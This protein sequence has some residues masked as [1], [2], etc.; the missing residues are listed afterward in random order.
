M[1]EVVSI[2]NLSKKFRSQKAV[3]NVNFTI[4]KGQICGLIGRNGAG[5]TTILKMLTGLM[6]SSEGSISLFGKDISKDYSVIKKI[7]AMI[8][9]PR[10]FDNMTA[11][12]NLKIK[13]LAIGDNNFNKIDELLKFVELDKTG[14]KKAKNFSYGMKQRLSLALALAGEPELLIL[15]EPINGLDPQGIAEVR[16]IILKV[17][18]EKNTTVIISSHVLEELTKIATQYVFIDKGTILENMTSKELEARQKGKMVLTVNDVDK[19]SK[20]LEKLDFKDIKIVD[21]S[22]IEVYDD[23]DNMDSL[24][25]D[26]VKNDV[27][28][29]NIEKNKTSLE[30]IYFSIVGGSKDD[31]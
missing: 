21:E 6:N 9:N 1:S 14:K 24:V 12:Q 20:V 15:D 28:I 2:N 10:I 29:K 31:K 13:F 4:K 19:T 11:Y 18:K 22:I 23:L 3:D 5:K 30:D 17:N 26:L 25:T 16:N 7:G 27:E 8:E